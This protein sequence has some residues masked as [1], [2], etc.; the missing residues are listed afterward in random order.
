M[1][2]VPFDLERH[3]AAGAPVLVAPDAVT[4]SASADGSLLYSE[5]S[6]VSVHREL[7]WLDRTGEE[8]GAVGSPHEEPWSA[9]AVPDG[10]RVAFSAADG[11]NEDVWV[12]DLKTGTETR[13]TFGPQKESKPEWLG[14]SSRLSYVEE[15]GMQGRVLS[16]N[17]DGSGEQRVLA[18]LMCF[19]MQSGGVTMAPDGRSA[20]RIVDQRGHGS[21]QV[22]PM[23]PDGT[24]GPLK[25]L[26][27]QVP[28][29]N[30]GAGGSRP[31][32][33]SSRTGPTTRDRSTSSWPGSPGGRGNGRSAPRAG[34]GPAGPGQR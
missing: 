21:L 30:V 25:P 32:A 28:E 13:L 16:I 19:G 9:A 14:S 31:T 22:G 11:G 5:G 8:I 10:H 18:P 34:F 17:A 1:W 27:K 3:Q 12:L 15:N 24:L 33:D 26:F 20:I 23:L 7:V 6:K 2:A 4:L 29:P